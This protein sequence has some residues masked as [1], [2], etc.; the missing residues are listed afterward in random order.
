MFKFQTQL[1]DLENY[2]KSQGDFEVKIQEDRYMPKGQPF[3]EISH[4]NFVNIYVNKFKTYDSLSN[5]K[6]IL[7]DFINSINQKSKL[8]DEYIKYFELSNK[9]KFQFLNSYTDQLDIVITHIDT[10]RKYFLYQMYDIVEQKYPM[11]NLYREIVFSPIDGKSKW[12]NLT[13][14]PTMH[15]ELTKFNR[16]PKPIEL[17]NTIL[18][19]LKFDTQSYVSYK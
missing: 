1:D 19:E 5:Y 7:K 2:L 15:I 11:F 18:N 8:F 17:D 16:Q 12:V 4:P 3:Y 9:Y 6:I 13:E 10:N 14:L